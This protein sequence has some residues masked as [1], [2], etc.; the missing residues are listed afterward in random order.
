MSAALQAAGYGAGYG[1]VVLAGL[2]AWQRRAEKR[3]HPERRPC[4]CIACKGHASREQHERL[5]LPDD[6]PGGES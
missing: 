3:R 6:N 4:H 5:G 2:Y 1:L